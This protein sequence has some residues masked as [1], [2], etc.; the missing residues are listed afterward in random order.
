MLRS[1]RFLLHFTWRGMAALAAF[2]AVVAAGCCATGVGRGADNLFASYYGA[3]PLFVLLVLFIFGFSL[4]GSGLNLAL[5]MGARRR[6]FFWAL[7]GAMAVCAGA[8]WLLQLALALL[9]ALAGWRADGGW[10]IIGLFR[11]AALALFPVACLA[12]LVLGCVGGL[13]CTRSK[14]WGGAVIV[15]AMLLMTAGAALLAVRSDAGAWAFL[16]DS[17]WSGLWRSLPG[18]LLLGML[19][20]GAA[21]EAVLWR[22]IQRFA[23]R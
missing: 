22:Q 5:S 20:A 1:F 21:A 15:G 17:G 11:G 18:A 4:C 3:F 6:D 19:A 23:V 12:I 14:V 8:G 9:P 2:G 10:G 7:Q 16:M 13:L